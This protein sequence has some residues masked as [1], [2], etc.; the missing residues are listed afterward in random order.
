MIHRRLAIALALTTSLALAACGDDDDDSPPPPMDSGTDTGVRDL[1]GDAQSGD[2]AGPVDAGTQ[3]G[4]RED[5][6]AGDAGVDPLPAIVTPDAHRV[7]ASAAGHDRYYGVAFAPDSS[8][9]VTGTWQTGTAATDDV[10]TVVAIELPSVHA[11][12]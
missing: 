4:G 5:G 10:E 12:E 7:P 1:G 3:D 6:G 8:F 9:Y 11:S 2:D